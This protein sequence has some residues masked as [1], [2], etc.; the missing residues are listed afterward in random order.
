MNVL[1]RIIWKIMQRFWGNICQQV[2]H[3]YACM[4]G[5]W[6]TL[7]LSFLLDC[8]F[9]YHV[10]MC[11]YCLGSEEEVDVIWYKII[12][13]VSLTNA[14][15]GK[16]WF[17]SLSSIKKLFE[18]GKLVQMQLT[19]NINFDNWEH[20]PTLH[21]HSQGVHPKLFFPSQPFAQ[22]A[23][24]NFWWAQLPFCLLHLLCSVMFLDPLRLGFW[25]PLLEYQLKSQ[26]LRFW[27]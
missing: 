7:N 27:S 13:K 12:K 26:F 5:L 2:N 16:A 1:F 10:S 4:L 20:W 18:M 15:P 23:R 22:V 9:Y 21:A 25:P 14:M 19:Q 6:I 8:G 17:V 24:A 11:N 3:S